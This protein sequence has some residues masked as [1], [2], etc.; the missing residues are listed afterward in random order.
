MHVLLRI[1]TASIMHGLCNRITNCAQYT[2]ACLL[3]PFIVSTFV[4]TDSV[5]R[6]YRVLDHIQH[7][8]SQYACTV[9]SVRQ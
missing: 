5:Y 6:T 1:A 2:E 4:V 3:N 9:R 7:K 8:R